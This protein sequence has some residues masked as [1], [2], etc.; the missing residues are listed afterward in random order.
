MRGE[1]VPV[2]DSEYKRGQQTVKVTRLLPRN[3]KGFVLQRIRDEAHRFAVEY[4]RK[5][6]SRD[7]ALDTR[8]NQNGK[9]PEPSQA[10]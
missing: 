6:R 2:I 5:L 3:S 9:T 1:D 4:H 10:L 7:D 8:R